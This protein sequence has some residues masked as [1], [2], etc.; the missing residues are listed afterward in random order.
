LPSDRPRPAVQSH[1]G[2]IESFTI[3]EA[4]TRRIKTMCVAE[5]V[6]LYMG[7]LAAFQALLWRYTGVDDIPVGTPVAGRNAAGP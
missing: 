1:H 5:G 2:S 3:D 6:T 7:L 4:L